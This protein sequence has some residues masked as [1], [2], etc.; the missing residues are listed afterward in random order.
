MLSE[1]TVNEL[2]WCYQI[3]G[4][5][6]CTNVRTHGE[7]QCALITHGEWVC[8]NIRTRGESV[9]TNVISTHGEWLC[10]LMLSELTVNDS[11][12]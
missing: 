4:E 8:T 3:S 12:H 5:W 1:L 11:A 2:H 7:D 10:A 6:V 9:C